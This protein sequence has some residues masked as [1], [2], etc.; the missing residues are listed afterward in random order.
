[1]KSTKAILS[2]VVAVLSLTAAV[3]VSAQQ[4]PNFADLAEKHGP[5]VVNISTQSRGGNQQQMP[6]LSEDD[7]FYEFFRRFMPPD[8]RPGPGNPA[9]R[10]GQPP[11]AEPKGPNRAPLR[12]FGM[13]SGFIISS[14][15]YMLTNAHVVENA[16]E[17][18]VRLTDKREFK[19][20]VVGADKRTDVAVI[21]IDATALP[22]VLIGDTG[23]L[24]VGDWV[25]AIGSPYGFSATVTAGIVSAKSRDNLNDRDMDS[26]PFIQTDAAVNPGN[27]GG[28][29]FNLKGEVVGINSQIYSRSGGFQGISFAIP[30]DVAMGVADQLIKTG[31]VTRG[32]I[33]VS[34]GNVSKDLAESLGLPKSDGA[35][36]GNV[37]EGS[38]AAKAGLEPGDVITKVDGKD[39][40]GSADLSRAIRAMKPGVAA[41]LS[42][43]RGGKLREVP[44][45]IGEFKEEAPTKVAKAGKPEVKP[46]KF[47]LALTD[48]TPE[49]KK[50]AKVAS[51]VLVD[52]VDGVALAAGISP[53]D[54][55]LRVNNTE[56]ANVKAFGDVVAKLDVKK[57]V[58]LLVKDENGT[59]FVTLRP[60]NE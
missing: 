3:A 26:V 52:G 41:K 59:R 9:P 54:V 8:A 18:I 42:V 6:G 57:P 46:G 24:R 43:W 4:L 5:A 16:D 20:R 10:R 28:P 30:I 44:V 51:G 40:E 11:G 15:G 25:M 31:K 14:D 48:L 33:G 7:P 45:T 12:P 13:G 23:K 60:E 29:L 19:A 22:K 50:Q 27:S 49:Q 36:I 35:V 17:I 34:I 2:Y 39:I 58:A 37:E 21:K 38:P 47:G 56:V 1:M 32:K 55:I 53:G